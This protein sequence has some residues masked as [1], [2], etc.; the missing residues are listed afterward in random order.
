MRC[1]K[2]LFALARVGDLSTF[3]FKL[4]NG[5]ST[6]LLYSLHFLVLYRE[7]STS[8]LV[9]WVWVWEAYREEYRSAFYAEKKRWFIDSKC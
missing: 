4:K 1:R 7:D 8:T 3:A 6:S 9:V 5:F 2:Y